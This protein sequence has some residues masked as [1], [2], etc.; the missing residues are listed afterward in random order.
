M[1]AGRNKSPDLIEPDGTG[2]N[3][4]GHNR[5]LQLQREGRGYTG[6]HEIGNLYAT[7]SS[8]ALELSP[9][10]AHQID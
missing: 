3:D 6:D 8:T 1:Q 4:A 10:P 7:R 5:D 9:R 2:R